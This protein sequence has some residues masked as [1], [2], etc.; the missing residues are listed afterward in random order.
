MLEIDKPELKQLI[1]NSSGNNSDSSDIESDIIKMGKNKD[2]PSSLYSFAK[3]WTKGETKHE[4]FCILLIQ[5]NVFIY[6]FAF[7]LQQP[8]LPYLTENLNLNAKLFGYLQSF[9]SLLMLLG[10]PLIGQ[11]TDKLGAKTSLQLCQF[12][13][14]L[15]YHCLGFA[16]SLQFLFVSRLFTTLQQ[17]M[18][19][20]QAYIATKT[21]DVNREQSLGK[22]SVCYGIGMIA[23]SALSGVVV[24]IFSLKINAHI[25]GLISLFIIVI[26]L[27]YLPNTTNKVT[28]NNDDNTK[29]GGFSDSISEIFELILRNH[30][31]KIMIF[32]FVAGFGTNV[33][34]S[35]FTLISKD[36]FQFSSSNIGFF[37][38]Y[39]SII[40]TLTNTFLVGP[41]KKY[42]SDSKIIEY[43]VLMNGICLGIFGIF[44]YYNITNIYLLCLLTIPQSISSAFM[45]IMINGTMSK[46]V[47][48]T[49]IGKSIALSHAIRSLISVVSPTG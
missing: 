6:A 46:I 10:G 38:A 37:I 12:G 16:N 36:T 27:L 18:Q 42:L 1:L 33:Y 40:A 29:K 13:S 5:F 25:S 4:I 17:V 11:M 31:K 30:I 2:N 47:N 22:L 15:S 49:E 35:M 41:T 43:S 28:K 7:W 8:L 34:R 19:T 21:K 32:V 9:V 20:S 23:G 14:A 44:C 24:R 45:Y 3:S 39:A 48:K 26:N